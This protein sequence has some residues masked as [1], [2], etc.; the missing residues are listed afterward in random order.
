MLEDESFNEFYAI[1]DDIVNP[2][3][4]IGENNRG[5]VNCKKIFM[6]HA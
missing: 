1:L 3:F 2:R 4:N 6:A 5:L